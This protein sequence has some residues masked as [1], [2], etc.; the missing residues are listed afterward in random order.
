MGTGELCPGVKRQG[1]EADHSPPVISYYRGQ[2][3][4]D[5]SP[6]PSIRLYG[7]V[8]A[9]LSTKTT[10]QLYPSTVLH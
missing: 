8:L 2:Q 6:I 7:V 5:L 9:K 4:L 10:L 3:N 1:R